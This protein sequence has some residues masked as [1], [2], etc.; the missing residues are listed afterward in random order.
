MTVARARVLAAAIAATG[1]VR[2]SASALLLLAALSGCVGLTA[3]D[4]SS[5]DGRLAVQV[6]AA[7]AESARSFAAPFTLRGDERAGVLELASPLGTMLA[8]AQWQPGSATLV[9][10]DGTRSY[11]TLDALA[12]DM[13]GE[14]LP[15]A[16][17]M[18]WLRGRPWLGAAHERLRDSAGFTQLGWSIDLARHGE[19]FVVAQRATP[20]PR[21]TVR[22]KI[23][24]RP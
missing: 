10:A 18:S 5:I 16:A 8:R 23:D 21:V 14:R 17:L 4:A 15:L 20:P 12:K 6:D 7:G 9:S 22:A 2:T 3:P 1:V 19:G 24:A 13:L 11:A